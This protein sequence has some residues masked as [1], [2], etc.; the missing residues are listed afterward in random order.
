MNYELKEN[1]FATA[2]PLVVSGKCSLSGDI[3][4]LDPFGVFIGQLMR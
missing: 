3:I 1:G 4:T 2:K